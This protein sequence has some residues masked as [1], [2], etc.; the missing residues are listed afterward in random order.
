[1]FNIGGSA[2]NANETHVGQINPR[3]SNIQLRPDT[4]IDGTSPLAARPPQPLP[5]SSSV[6]S[7]PR[8]SER[9]TSHSKL[10]VS[11][12][13][14]RRMDFFA[15]DSWQEE[16]MT[17]EEL[18]RRRWLVLPEAREKIAWDWF[19]VFNVLYNLVEIPLFL[20]FRVARPVGL[21]GINVLVDL[22][23]LLAVHG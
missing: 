18:A 6:R 12:A 5:R 11:A 1:M 16:L 20:G 14:K 19:V 13:F 23:L 21:I 9:Q 2:S 15:S 17:D 7:E 10:Q 22:V 4:G 8:F 3:S